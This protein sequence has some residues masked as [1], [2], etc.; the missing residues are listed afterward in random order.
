MPTNSVRHEECWEINVDKGR[1]VSS[2]SKEYLFHGGTIYLPLLF[3]CFM[4]PG[5]VLCVDQLIARYLYMIELWL[6]LL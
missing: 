3:A 1:K 4:K 2:P 6:L 5:F